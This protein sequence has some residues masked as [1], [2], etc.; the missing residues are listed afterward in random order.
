[1]IYEK[2]MKEYIFVTLVIRTDK[3]I[4]PVNRYLMPRDIC[5]LTRNI[6]ILP[7]GEG[8]KNL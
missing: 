6:C 5:F 4:N 7:L 3:D 2:V 1:M 8:E